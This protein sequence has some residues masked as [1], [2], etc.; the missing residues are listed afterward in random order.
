MIYAQEVKEC[1]AFAKKAAKNQAAYG[2]SLEEIER[3]TI[4]GKLGETGVVKFF[5]YCGINVPVNA[6]VYK[7]GEC[8]KAD[9]IYNQW[10]IDVKTTQQNPSYLRVP[11]SA[12]NFRA[13]N[14][15]LSDYYILVRLEPDFH[16]FQSPKNT[17]VDLL[18]YWDVEE[19]TED[20]PKVK[21]EYLYRGGRIKVPF[22][23][24]HEDML[25]KNF[26]KLAYVIQNT[27][28]DRNLFTDNYDSPEKRR[29][30][31]LTIKEDTKK[32]GS[33]FNM[34]TE[35]IEAISGSLDEEIDQ[36]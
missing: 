5:N 30:L 9:I 29:K 15:E 22:F 34:T 32:Y 35:E 21:T 26:R 17:W 20:N 10:P 18:G 7:Y 24:V 19:F 23:V 25:A 11:W 14:K 2:R 8:D 36:L 1:I 27:T 13:D 31:S 28:Y 16:N 6:Q 33:I 3:N 12:L 4:V